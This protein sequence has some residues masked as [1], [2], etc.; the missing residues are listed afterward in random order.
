[1][2][3]GWLA[4]GYPPGCGFPGSAYVSWRKTQHHPELLS[5]WQ[6]PRGRDLITTQGAEDSFGLLSGQIKQQLK[7][8]ERFRLTNEHLQMPDHSPI[9]PLSATPAFQSHF[10]PL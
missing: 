2:V 10:V 3:D 9:L 4:G 8:R 5:S 7:L 1:M 6:A